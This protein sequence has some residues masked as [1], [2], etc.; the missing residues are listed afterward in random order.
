MAGRP[1]GGRAAEFPSQISEIATRCSHLVRPGRDNW[2]S[3]RHEVSGSPVKPK[4]VL[5]GRWNH[6]AFSIVAPRHDLFSSFS[7][8]IVPG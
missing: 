8:N 7:G 4:I 2:K 1:R 6:R 3:A 5:K